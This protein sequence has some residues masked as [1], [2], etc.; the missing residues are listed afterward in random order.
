[1]EGSQLFLNDN[2]RI[3]RYSKH[4]KHIQQIKLLLR[5]EKIR[6]WVTCDA[7][8]RKHMKGQVPDGCAAMPDTLRPVICKGIA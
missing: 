8:C 7:N 3:L 4:I 2:W 5:E 6:A 1:M